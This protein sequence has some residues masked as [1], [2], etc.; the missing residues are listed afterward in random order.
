VTALCRTSKIGEIG[1][2]FLLVYRRVIAHW[3]PIILLFILGLATFLIAHADFFGLS[4]FALLLIFIASQLFWIGRILGLGERFIPGKPRR[5]WLAIIAGLVYLFVFTYSYHEWGLGHTIRAADYRPQS[6]LIHAVFWWWFVGSLLA[7]L[8]VIAFAAADRVARAAGW[9]YRKVPTAT[10]Q[11]SAA[12]DAEAPLLSSGRRRFL[13]RT[14]VLVSTTPF[15][16]AGYGLLYERQN[17]EVVRQ[18]IRLARLPKAFEGFHI[19]QLSDIHIGPFTNADYIRRCVAITNGLEPDLIALTGDYVCWDPEDQGGVVRVLAGLHAPHGVF[20]CLGNHEADVGIEE[21]ITRLFAAQGIRMLRQESAPICLRGDMLN[22][23]GIDHGSD[24][25][26]IHAQQVEGY[27][28]LQQLK[29]LVMPNTVNILLIHYPHAF[30]DPQ[31]LGIDLTLAGDIHGGGQ[32]SL[33]FIHRGL[34]LG[35]LMEVPYIRGLY[36][37]RHAMRP[38]IG[39][40]GGAQLYMNRG[41]GI[42]GFPIRL[43][44]RPEITVLELTREA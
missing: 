4:L 43:G 18:R 10:H 2:S 17:V 11:H 7:F 32:L 20:G 24:L 25:V 16:A 6:M 42:T 9:A 35:S 29:A 1:G 33:D 14:A 3:R 41:I 30:G 15:L 22:L 8:L 34:N 39:G 19:A 26:P 12:A 44:A 36:E 37:Y 28:R 31:L 40:S 27:R 5:L 23:I 13:E 38:V 21:S